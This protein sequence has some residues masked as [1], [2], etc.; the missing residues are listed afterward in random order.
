MSETTSTDLVLPTTGE[1]VDITDPNALAMALNSLRYVESEIRE[2]KAFISR[3]LAVEAALRGTRTIELKDGRKAVVSSGTETEYDSEAIL[4]GLLAAGMPP[5]R[6]SEV[7]Q[8]TIQYKV[9]AVE[10]KRAAAANAAYATVIDEN[11]RE[12]DK[13]VTVSI[14]RS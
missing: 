9:R 12:V 1:I 8:E 11:S 4:E 2:C 14:R 5:E 3:T 7:V 10:A 13:P 6:V